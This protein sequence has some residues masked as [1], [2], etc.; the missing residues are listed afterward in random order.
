MA[1]WDARRRRR[2]HGQRSR[3]ARRALAATRER[4]GAARARAAARSSAARRR[5]PAAACGCRR[6]AS[7]SPTVTTTR[8]SIALEYMDELIGDEPPGVVARAQA[9]VRLER[10]QDAGVLR[11]ARPEVPPHH[12]VSRLLP[13]L[14][15]AAAPPDAG[16]E[17]VI[18][19]HER[20]RRLGRQAA[21]A[22]PSPQPADGHARRGQDPRSRS[23]RVTGFPTAREDL[24]A[25]L[26]IA[27]AR[28]RSSSAAAARSRRSCCT[29]RCSATS[30]SGS[31]RGRPSSCVE[32]GRVV[33]IVAER[34]GKPVRIQG[35]PRRLPRRRRLRAERGDAPALPARPDHRT[36]GRPPRRA[37]LGDG[38]N[39]G[40][41]SAPRMPLMDEAWWGPAS[42]LTPDGPA[43]FHVSERSKPGSLIVDQSGVRYFNES[44]DYVLAGQTMFERTRRGACDPFVADLRQQLPQPLSVRRPTCRATRPQALVDSGYFKRA[45]HSRPGR[46]ARAACRGR[47]DGDGDA[48]Q[49]VRPRG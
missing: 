14:H 21:Q 24:R 9:G 5:S 38:I 49:R 7:C 39:L 20:A 10:A 2:G 45:G 11:V 40:H 43:I 44:T 48:L 32:D 28:G 30:R 17:S 13:A 35:A 31:R 36:S 29:S 3:R 8:P 42:V 33:G 22:R 25:P 37:D 23:A 34:D 16:I 18:F 27:R 46:E 4:A 15:R 12:R 26:P 19:E 1:D 47:A 41:R 6:T